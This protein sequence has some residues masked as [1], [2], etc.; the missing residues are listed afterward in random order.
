VR[1]EREGDGYDVHPVTVVSIASVDLLARRADHEGELDP[2]RFRMLM[3]L[4]GCEPHEEDTWDGR[5]VRI[6]EAV[7]RMAGPVP[8]CVVTTQDPETGLKDF[9]TLKH[10]RRTRGTVADGRSRALMFGMYAD[11]VEPGRIRVG[12]RL[13]LPSR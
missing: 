6:G 5:A 10:I 9:E 7:V 3:D 11:V 1:T 4:D 8:R 12:D 2:R 13:E